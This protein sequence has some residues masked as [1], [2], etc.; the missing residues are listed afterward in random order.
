MELQCWE[1]TIGQS[2]FSLARLLSF[3]SSNANSKRYEV[4]GT[5]IN[6]NASLKLQ[7]IQINS[8]Y[9][10]K[11]NELKVRLRTL[12]DKKKIL[13][14]DT[15]RL[16]HASTLFNAIQEAFIQFEQ[17]LNKIQVRKEKIGI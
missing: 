5:Y 12:V 15:R 2:C 4:N 10:Q 14:T 17:E 6:S 1:K 16:K 7:H 13:Q 8:F 11:E 9:L 3:L